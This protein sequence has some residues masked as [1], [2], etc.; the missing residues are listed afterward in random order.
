M[1]ETLRYKDIPDTTIRVG[2]NYIKQRYYITNYSTET[3]YTT[4]YRPN[5]SEIRKVLEVFNITETDV[6]DAEL[7]AFSSELEYL[8]TIYYTWQDTG[9]YI[10]TLQFND[11]NDYPLV[12]D[13]ERSKLYILNSPIVYDLT[14]NESPKRVRVPH[15][16]N[17]YRTTTGLS[18]SEQDMLQLYN[19]LTKYYKPAW[20]NQINQPEEDTDP[21][22]YS[23]VF[24]LTNYNDTSLAK[25][26]CIF[27]I[28]GDEFTTT[29]HLTEINTNTQQLTLLEE[30]N[31]IKVGDTIWVEDATTN[32]S[33]E[34]FS[35]DGTYTVQDISEDKLTIT[36][37]ETFPI[38]YEFSY[39]TCKVIEATYT[40]SKMSRENN[41]ITVTENPTDILVGDKIYVLGA[42]VPTTYETISC[43]GEYTVQRITREEDNYIITVE[44]TIPTDFTTDS[45]TA[46]LTKELFVGN[47]SS[48]EPSTETSVIT[49]TNNLVVTPNT[50]ATIVIYT[51]TTRNT[52]TVT[53][54][55]T[56]TCTV[57]SVISAYN[58]V[59]H[60]PKC[61]LATPSNPISINITSVDKIIEETFPI[62][63][64]IV[65]NFAEAQ[66]YIETAPILP[67]PN[68]MYSNY[69]NKTVPTTMSIEE[70]PTSHINT[71]TCKGLYTKNYED[72][73]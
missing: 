33:G 38:S 6:T 57:S 13:C 30:N 47:I 3:V 46:T 11:F 16:C 54:T 45:T 63:E 40:I 7:L 12:I 36:I 35:A 64:F 28:L 53:G 20:Y 14:V 15:L 26:H 49:M 42:T 65:N 22:T 66:A 61:N 31:N 18:I 70:L 72:G 34:E 37:A 29:Y 71:M 51:D 60:T 2:Y 4:T 5:I 9:A 48:I 55:T 39:N 62:G 21:L 50:S 17:F 73:I 56:N 32:Y 23:G 41:T 10:H 25:C 59:E 19:L 43:D 24:A 68:E 52:Y 58:I 1:T 69:I 8:H 67:I 44:E 27:N